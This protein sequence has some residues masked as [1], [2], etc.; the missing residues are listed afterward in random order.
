MG[1]ALSNRKKLDEFGC[2]I[3]FRILPLL[4][5]C[6]S[7]KENYMNRQ[8]KYPRG[9]EW[10][11]WDLH[12]HSPATVLNNQFEGGTVDE[13][14]EKYLIKLESICDV[15]VLGVTDYFSID[16]YVK[17]KEY[18]GKGRIP[19]IEL[20][21]PNVEL[22]LLPVTDAEY[23]IN[24][25][26]LFAPG[27]VDKLDSQFFQ[28]LEFQYGGSTY[29]AT[30][31]DLVRL[32][33]D[34]KNDQTVSEHVAY[35]DGVNQFKITVKQLRD[36]LEKNRDL[37]R[38]CLIAVAN[39]S[40]DGNS[41]IQKN[42]LAATRRDIYRFS[43]IIF[44]GNPKDAL[45]FIGRGKDSPEIIKQDYGSLK[46]CVIGS[47][48]H[49][50]TA[51]CNPSNGRFTWVKADPTF[52]GLCQVVNEPAERVVVGAFPFKL[53]QVHDNKTKYL[54]NITL[55]RK[56][57]ALIEEVWFSNSIPINPGLVA[58]IGNKGK[59]KSA[60]VDIVGLLCNTKQYRDFT[61]L[62]EKNFRQP[63]N[64]KARHFK[65]TLLW[66]SGESI[67][68]GLEEDVDARQ[69]ELVKYIPQNFLE[70]ICT[71]LGR[72]EESDF[73][74][75]LKKVIFSHVQVAERLGKSTLDELIAE[76]T[77][78]ATAKIQLLKQELHTINEG[79]IALEEQASP[80]F[81]LKVENLLKVKQQ[82]LEAHEKTKPNPIAKPENDPAKQ[83]QISDASAAI[84]TAKKELGEFEKKIVRTNQDLLKVAQLIATAE[85]LLARIENLNRQLKH[86][87]EESKHAFEQLGILEESVLKV[88]VDTRSVINK[89]DEFVARKAAL[90]AQINPSI[91][92]SYPQRVHN[93]QDKI[94][95]LR[96]TL[97]EPN[98]LYQAYQTA[99]GEWEN[100]KRSI[101]G[102]DA[103]VDTVSCY[104]LQLKKLGA[105]PQKL[106]DARL[107][108]LNKSK[109]IHA[110]IRELAK[111]YRQ[112][113][114][115]VHQ[116]IETRPLAKEKFRLNFEA[117][118]VDSGF[119]EAFF[120]IVTHAVTGTFCGV[121]DGEKALKRILS[122][123]DFNTEAG[124]E[125]FL[126]EIMD[127]LE[128]DK[129]T[130]G[131]SVSVAGQIRKGKNTSV[132]T[133]Y[134]LIFSLDYLKPR[135]A[136]RMGDKELSQL[137][138]G[139]RGILLLVFYLL[140]DK[141]NI[142]L[143]IDQPE[144]NLDNQTVYELLVP[145]IKEAKERRQIFIV[146][147]NPNLAV[148][149]DADQVIR[150]D[151]D[152]KNRYTMEYLSGSI[153]NPAINRAIVD[154]LEG[155]MPAFHNRDSKY[156]SKV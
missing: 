50:L 108:R 21:I 30:R 78:E 40:Q 14:W 74:H 7:Q 97:D 16:G 64:N 76:R 123:H 96:T 36:V 59:G 80:D 32:G 111:A 94:D 70:K 5:V 39:S 12:I 3:C 135:Y 133:L 150:A 151:L 154:V 8:I 82:E 69:P 37:E 101:I 49:D 140:V 130:G 155:T 131:N 71:E 63:K 45:Y 153:E 83:K 15:A 103:A 85:K 10:R 138:P 19:K 75:E 139:E 113:Y 112:L 93:L 117:S 57:D 33:R 121:E 156:L 73:D 42:S 51:V 44:S 114:A 88:V 17:L 47:D 119:Q 152:K 142:P 116:F 105:V 1:L 146:T 31:A 48:A 145:C 18:K 65:A 6:S 141:D 134:N 4:E 56:S 22:R 147:H 104:Q 109:E 24:L 122:L 53:K 99:L 9:S 132:L 137:S 120:G 79:I 52:E 38:N 58:I 86:F 129:R 41:G 98:K 28:N 62:S 67:T 126:G 29:K 61:F 54:K 144:E 25:H 11:K 89:R 46:P 60:L 68:R 115:P 107:D 100:K 26:L 136:L 81:R 43:H 2:L 20:L 110:V 27:I 35:A 72:I 143:V 66:E 127:S 87:T 102:N 23:P 95:Q 91:K 92:D 125:S 84:E 13:K 118:I 55:E 106:V 148:V 128:H 149:C 34:F 124:I 77:S 90:E